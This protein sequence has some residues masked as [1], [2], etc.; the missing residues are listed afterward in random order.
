M[1][2]G[3]GAGLAFA[4]ALAGCLTPPEIADSQDALD[5]ALA[6]A[7]GSAVGIADH[8]PG[9]VREV[10]GVWLGSRVL[11]GRRG[12]PLP[13][14]I[15]SIPVTLLI[16]AGD[17]TAQSRNLLL[18]ET[19]RLSGLPIRVDPVSIRLVGD[20]LA[21]SPAQ[22]AQDASAEED[23]EEAAPGGL[24]AFIA[25][26]YREGP[27]D[28]D[29]YHDGIVHSLLGAVSSALG[30]AGWVY[31][32]GAVLFY[33]HETRDLRVDVLAGGASDDLLGEL[34]EAI[35]A[36][37]G[38]CRVALRPSL[39][40]YQVTARP[41]MIERVERYLSEL[42]RRL[43]QQYLVEIEV[44]SVVREARSDLG[45]DLD[46]AFGGNQIDVAF[47]RAGQGVLVLEEGAEFG[48][49][50]M[51]DVLSSL[52]NT[53]I[54]HRSSVLA[55]DGRSQTM[56]IAR[57]DKVRV[58]QE[59]SV[60]AQGET[61][62]VTDILEDF[63]DGVFLTVVPRRVDHGRLLLGYDL[64]I[65]TVLVPQPGQD[66]SEQ[67]LKSSVDER[68]LA[69]EVVLPIG[70]KVVFNAFER[71]RVGSAREGGFTPDIWIFGGGS[72]AS[73][74]VETLV[75]AIRAGR[76]NLDQVLGRVGAA[77]GDG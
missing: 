69:N 42:N 3:V 23:A 41:S 73:E 13:V 72:E 43:T 48:V 61:V 51:V 2:C 17:E 35:L 45:F 14:E 68:K 77:S 65:N 24:A 47:G 6:E 57:T 18:T 58:G 30:F 29:F 34:E 46:V 1:A 44:F 63:T 40:V 31:E 22:D 64:Q 16:A 5:Q 20:A 26:G 32:E 71:K 21:L 60:N 52:G 56:E 28:D 67:A 8:Q 39:G 66:T 62:G 19:Q 15:A 25:G 9:A 33:L 75:V 49:D 38:D 76:A 53:S 27:L 74:L 50:V 59:V 4:F 70:A 55:L 37:C 54:A 10:A 12:D 36:I 11:E 7:V